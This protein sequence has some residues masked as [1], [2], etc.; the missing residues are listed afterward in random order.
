MPELKTKSIC[1]PND[2]VDIVEAHSDKIDMNLILL[3][4]IDHCCLI[5]EYLV[6]RAIEGNSAL[7][8]KIMKNT[9]RTRFTHSDNL[10]AMRYNFNEFMEQCEKIF[11]NI[12]YVTRRPTSEYEKIKRDLINNKLSIY[13]EIVNYDQVMD[14]IHENTTKD[15]KILYIDSN[16]YLV[17][18]VNPTVNN[19]T[20][21][22]M[23]IFG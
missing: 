22:K 10:I 23:N 19:L 13:N 1:N 11:T 6:T 16:D 4:N 3:I 15:S 17:N 5:P 12:Y 2:I 9:K 14:I 8:N 7:R 21:Y 20:I 18:K